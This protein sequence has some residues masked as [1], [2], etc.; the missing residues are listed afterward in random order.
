[1][2]LS[3]N[4]QQVMLKTMANDFLKKELPKERVREI[5][6]SP[7]G[8]SPDLWKQ[9]AEL[10]WT[11]MVIPEEYGGTGNS[12]TDLGVVYEELGQAACSSPTLSSAVLSAQ[13]ILEAGDESQKKAVLP[14]IALGEQIVSFAYTEPEYGWGP[15]AV[16][17]KATANNGGYVL[18]GVKLFV[19][20]AHV[21][22]QLLVV[23]RTSDKGTAEQGLSLFLIDK[24]AK[25]VSVRLQTGWIGDKVCEI[26]L[27]NVAVPRS[28]LI[29]AADEAWPAI[30]KARDRGTAIL[31]AYMAGGARKV[32]DMATEYCQTR[33]A[34]GVTIGT[35]QRVQDRVIQALDDADSTLWSAYEAL[36]RLDEGREDAA[37]GV[38]SAKAIA[39][40]AFPRA[41][42]MSHHVHAGIGTDLDFGLLHYTKRAR[43]FQNYLGDANFHKKRLAT[44]MKL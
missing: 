10:G 2:D 26:K 7:T 12:L 33:R 23:A 5:D 40:V 27:A 16:Q 41:C 4:E 14:A 31:C 34:C 18:D 30:E 13:A 25:G 37:V 1:M 43:T 19:P 36:W 29:G 22:D 35:F 39:S 44:L 21:A 28:S 6:E 38:S 24:E 8:F 42:E 9:M 17:L 20:D 15:A 3:L 32:V 11:G